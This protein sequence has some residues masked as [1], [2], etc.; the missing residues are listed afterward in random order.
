MEMSLFNNLFKRK[1]ADDGTYHRDKTAD[2]QNADLCYGDTMDAFSRQGFACF[3]LTVQDVFSITGRGT[4]IVGMVEAGSVSVGD[5]VTL[6]RADG[7]TRAV[8]VAGIEKFRKIMD[9]AVQ[10]ENVGL[11]L[12]QLGRNEVGKGDILEK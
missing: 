4:V 7:S 12:R 11:L 1:P 9:T 10:G 5:S 6:R 8:T 3:R 2:A